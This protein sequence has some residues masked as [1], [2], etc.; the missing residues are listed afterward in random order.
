[1]ISWRASRT[2]R[3]RS[4][5]WLNCKNGWRPSGWKSNQARRP[6]VVS[7]HWHRGLAN[8]TGCDAPKPSTSCGSPTSSRALAAVISPWATR[9]SGNDSE[10]SSRP[11]GSACR[12]FAS[13]ELV[14]W[15]RSCGA[16][17]KG[18]FSTTESA[19]IHA[20]CA[21]TYTARP[22]FSSTGS[23]VAVSDAP[24]LGRDT[25]PF[26]HACYLAFALCTTYIPQRCDELTLGAG[27]CNAPSPVL[28]GRRDVPHYRGFALLLSTL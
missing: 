2:S 26:C 23:T 20:A 6:R 11:W 12:G 16:I 7:G 3:T 14:Q 4:D 15:L 27:W 9:R 19:G 28:R 13:R 8:E 5:S 18:T 21:A 22:A 1:M 24:S 25:L 10:R 17:W